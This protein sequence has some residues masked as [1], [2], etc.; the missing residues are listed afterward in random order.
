[1]SDEVAGRLVGAG[2]VSENPRELLTLAQLY[3]TLQAAIWSEL[4]AHRDIA[5]MRRGLQREYLKHL[6][7]A[8]LKPASGPL[9]DVH[10]LARANAIALREHAQKAL[11]GRPA[12][13]ETRAHLQQ[14]VATI[15]DALKATPVKAGP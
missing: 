10:S 8:I 14:T 6:S 15:D 5:P 1:M 7:A 3:D 2:Y 12:S 11:A 13:A 4:D 9:A